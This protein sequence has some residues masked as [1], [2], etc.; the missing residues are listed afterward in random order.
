M[1]ELNG[2]GGNIELSVSDVDD[3]LM[4]IKADYEREYFVTGTDVYSLVVLYILS[5]NFCNCH[6]SEI[7]MDRGTKFE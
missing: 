2:E 5:S 4:I 7:M 6:K 3:V 1:D